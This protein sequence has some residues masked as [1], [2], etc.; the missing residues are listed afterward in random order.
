MARRLQGAAAVRQS[1]ISVRADHPSEH[2]HLESPII[3]QAEVAQSR[4]YLEEL[5][6]CSLGLNVFLVQVAR[7]TI[8]DVVLTFNIKKIQLLPRPKLL[9]YTAYAMLTSPSESTAVPFCIDV[10]ASLFLPCVAR[11]YR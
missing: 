5:K 4:A 6:Q 10:D 9:R 8:D 7:V 1:F 3:V 2:V 11:Q